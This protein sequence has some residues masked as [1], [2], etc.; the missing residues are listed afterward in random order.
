MIAFLSRS[1][2]MRALMPIGALFVLF[3]VVAVVGFATAL[4]RSA[5][6]GLDQRAELAASVLVGGAAEMLWNVDQAGGETLLGALKGDPDFLGAAIRGVD[7]Q[8]F[9]K[10]GDIEASGGEVVARST[11]VLRTDNRGQVQKLG[12]IELWLSKKRFEDQLSRMLA[13]TA[14]ASGLGILAACAILAL[15]IRSITRPIAGMTN[16]MSALAQGDTKVDV[17]A[18][19]RRD[20]VGRMAAAVQTFKDNAIE[21]ERLEL[22]H[23][24]LK[25][26]A[27]QERREALNKVAANFETEVLSVMQKITGVVRDM[28]SSADV[29]ARTAGDN[30]SMSRDAADSAS[31]VSTN[32]QTVAAAVTELAAS[33]RE[34][35]GQAA[36]SHK[37]ADGAAER[38]RQTVAMVSGLVQAANRIG[39]V[40]TLITSIASQTNLLALNATIEAARAGEAGKGFA[41]VANEVKNL[42]TQTGKATEEISAQIAAIQQSTAGAASEISKIVEVIN[43]ISEISA[44]IASAVEEQNAAT[45]EINRSVL[46]AS[47]ASQALQGTIDDV[48]GSARDSGSAADRLLAAIDQLGASFDGLKGQVD[49]FMERLQ[50]A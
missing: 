15:I 40:V 35:S 4:S 46:I 24:H 49:I 32:V 20:E 9:A 12:A 45:E 18:L 37:V 5:E 16:T 27:E 39:D 42:A 28:G 48:A 10:L 30:A 47:D 1:L 11:P 44:S 38:A 36:N 25:D 31:R 6:E 50:A 26:R 2:L 34:I 21:K 33:V 13:V 41:V 19:G 3:G 17:P 14:L 29:M 22:E 43:T 7:G 8:V 23:R